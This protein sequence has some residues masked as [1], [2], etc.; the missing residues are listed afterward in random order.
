MPVHSALTAGE[1]TALAGATSVRVL[2]AV[3]PTTNETARV[4]APS[5]LTFPLAEL[6]ID[7]LSA[8]FLTNVR[9]GQTV[10]IGS[11]AGARDRGVYRIRATPGAS[12]LY[13]GEI[14]AGD[15]GRMAF[16]LRAAA[17][18]DND[19]I[20][21]FTSHYDLWS[22][23]SIIDY[24]GENVSFF[25]DFNRAYINENSAPPPIVNLGKH[26]WLQP[27]SGQTYATT[28]I[29]ATPVA[30][31]GTVSSYSWLTPAW[32]NTSGTTTATLSG[33]APAGWSYVECTVTLS[34]GAAFT[35]R[36]NVYVYDRNNPP[37]PV[38]AI[39][40][41]ISTRDGWRMTL[42]L[43][44]NALASY[45]EGS[46]VQI[47]LECTWN[48]AYG[49]VS[50]A[51]Q[52]FTGWIV[53]ETWRTTPGL[54]DGQIEIVG[55]GFI[56]QR[57]LNTSQ[58]LDESGAPS[59]W[60]EALPSLTKARYMIHYLLSYHAPNLL[61][62]FDLTFDSMVS[63]DDRLPAIVSPRSTLWQQ[64]K[65]L[66]FRAYLEL[67]C[68]ETGA[69]YCIRHPNRTATASRSSITNRATLTPSIYESMTVEPRSAP[70]VGVVR[71]SANA[72]DG[73]GG[74]V[75]YESRAPGLKAGQGSGEAQLGEQI[76][77]SQATLD[78]RTGLAYA[79]Q[80]AE[81]VS[82]NVTIKKAWTVFSPAHLYFVQLQNDAA[83]LPRAA[84]LAIRAIPHTVTR[85]YDHAAGT[86]DIDAGFEP[87]TSGV[88]AAPK[89][90]E[91]EDTSLFGDFSGGDWALD[92]LEP[93]FEFPAL[94]WGAAFT[95][96]PAS[97]MSLSP[98]PGA[99][100][101]RGTM[102]HATKDAYVVKTYWDAIGANHANLSPTSAQ[103]AVIGEVVGFVV[104]LYNFKQYLLLGTTGVGWTGD[105]TAP[106]VIWKVKSILTSLYG[107]P[108]G[109]FQGIQNKKN[110]WAW[111]SRRAGDFSN[112]YDFTVSQGG[113]Q[114][115]ID[116]NYTPFGGSQSSCSSGVSEGVYTPGV[117]F[118]DAYIPCD[119]ARDYRGIIIGIIIPSATLTRISA[120]FSRTAGT[121][122]GAASGDAHQ[123]LI[124]GTLVASVAIDTEPSHPFEWT[125]T[126]ANATT[127]M[128]ALY[129]GYAAD[130]DPGGSVIIPQITVEGITTDNDTNFCL[131][132]DFFSA[133]RKTRL[134]S[135]S[136]LLANGLTVR[137]DDWRIMWAAAGTPGTD[138]KI[139]KSINGGASFTATGRTLSTRGGPVWMNRST[140]TPNVRNTSESNL[141][142]LI[143]LDGSNNVQITKGIPGTPTT[144][145]TDATRY[146]ET[147][148]ALY[149]LPRDLDFVNYAARTGHFYRSS[150]AGA[151]WAASASTIPG[152]ASKVIRA[153]TGWP[154]DSNFVAACGLEC[155]AYSLDRGDTWVNVYSDSY[156]AWRNANLGAAVGKEIVAFRPDLSSKYPISPN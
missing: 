142:T 23:F 7:G 42:D 96:T 93:L 101:Q 15:G 129:S 29:T 27:D 30:W 16:N 135:H 109:G 88:D 11:S 124:N 100:Q 133:I 39:A 75:P 92:Q 77:D 74:L 72:Y 58:R 104:N 95:F 60:Q 12:T 151:T 123:I 53:G 41:D 156:D 147:G 111:L 113:W 145:V 141:L 125:G 97:L 118:E 114:I 43:A 49:S 108:F 132:T 37:V 65:A 102:Y 117:G 87:E 19:H 38:T 34:T 121:Q 144:I 5:G 130:A 6:P 21:I 110:A 22:V 148:E 73:A 3:L 120:A 115:A 155:L 150:N 52:D 140:Q 25:K 105:I 40:S 33:R 35:A 36:R 86:M 78:G 112:V 99:A 152:G 127:I 80:N 103:R 84:A 20:T 128:I 131:T 26:L 18:S 61:K 46:M 68:D 63:T 13:I 138:A 8:N 71:G 119:G 62:L 50:S 2:A 54:R 91:P 10:W 9:A 136:L 32:T 94:D 154:T 47:R 85:R 83:L 79:Y 31:I 116:S 4:N 56:L 107:E 14:G 137:S 59:T 153:I 106:T 64:C 48:D 69:I 66:A 28:S 134:A 51:V 67:T 143:G 57:L 149:A 146:P 24:D 122:G 44:D 139:Y 89:A 17:I 82:V 1:L 98:V 70:E 76:V 126:F 90:I 45:P 55:P 81:I